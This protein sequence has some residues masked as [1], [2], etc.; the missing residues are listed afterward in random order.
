MSAI[1]TKE[2]FKPT[3]LF[4]NIGRIIGHHPTFLPFIVFPIGNGVWVIAFSFSFKSIIPTV[5]QN[6]IV[7][8]SDSISA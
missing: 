5:I 3:D 6:R 7:I 2:S 1:R 4:I 8:F